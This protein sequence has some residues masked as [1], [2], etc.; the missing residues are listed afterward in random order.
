MS[1][2]LLYGIIAI[3]IALGLVMGLTNGFKL[4]LTY[5]NNEKIEVYLGQEVN[6]DEIKQIATEVFGT[7]NVKVQTVE[8]FKDMAA[9]TVESSNDEQ[10]DRL[11]QIVNEKYGKEYTKEDINIIKIPSVVVL[12]IV[13]EYIK[14][15]AIIVIVVAVYMAVRYL[16]LSAWKV[17]LW[18]IINS[19][20]S[21]A[22]LASVYTIAKLPVNDITMPAALGVLTL[23]IFATSNYFDKKLVDIKNEEPKEEI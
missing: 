9:I 5:T 17:A 16:K 10:I 7:N 19:V 6:K 2:K 12:D 18:S 22:T 14:P 3:V 13:K 1:N 20:L 15:F 23:A 8:I 11:V 4:G 21:V